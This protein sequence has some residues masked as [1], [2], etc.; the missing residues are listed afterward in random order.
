[1]RS[2][3]AKAQEDSK[4]H[5]DDDRV[6]GDLFDQDHRAK[7]SGMS[8]QFALNSVALAECDS[9]S[10]ASAQTNKHLEIW[11]RFFKNAILVTTSS[12]PDSALIRRMELN[13]TISRIRRTSLA[14]KSK[15][16]TFT[17][18]WPSRLSTHRYNSVIKQLIL[19]CDP[20]REPQMTGSYVDDEKN[21]AELIKEIVDRGGAKARLTLQCIDGAASSFA[22]LLTALHDDVDAAEELLLRKGADPNCLDDQLRTP[23]HYCS[24]MGNVSMLALLFDN[25]A[26]LEGMMSA[27]AEPS[28][29][30]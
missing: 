10:A 6:R 2:T 16:A 9:N 22:L 5:V 23:T 8:D 25:G 1:M 20:S 17:A 30:T 7:K 19:K 18:R 12:D 15:G 14:S 13:K 4:H 21:D 28:I 26:D 3:L 24:R 29:I 11:E 27:F